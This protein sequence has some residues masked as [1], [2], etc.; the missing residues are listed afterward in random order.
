MHDFF[1]LGGLVLH[2]SQDFASP[3]ICEILVLQCLQSLGG[4]GGGGS[5]LCSGGG[6]GLGGDG[7]GG[8]ALAEADSGGGGLGNVDC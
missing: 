1:D 4:G 3:C 7:G 6:E 2:S 5:G 8:G